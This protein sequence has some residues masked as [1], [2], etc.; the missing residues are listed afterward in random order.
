MNK[1]IK[2]GKCIWCG[3]SEPQAT[4]TTK[5][6]VV[7]RSLGADEIGFDICD[8]CNHYFGTPIN[9]TPS[10]DLAFKE[11]FNAYRVFSNNLSNETWKT[12]KSAFFT[13][14]HSKRSIKIKPNFKV[15]A[16]TNQF[17]R[18]LFEIFL[19][20]YH[21]ETGDGNNHKFDFVR[22]FARF[23]KGELR[24]YYA[25]NKILLSPD[26]KSYLQLSM[27]SELLKDIDDYGVYHF[28]LLGH[29]FY[30]E[31]NPIIFN[32]YGDNYLKIR[33]HKDLLPVDNSCRILLLENIKDLDMFMLRFNS[34]NKK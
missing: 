22:D 30:L 11:V 9:G 1:Y 24:V 21:K 16:F 18:G 26:D 14:H 12:Y 19:Q 7:P 34:K 28:W 23:A 15:A 29:N 8:D 27:S 31:F 3:K 10:I 20:K 25:F 17:K 4:F 2:T 33:A 6:H 32:L 5:P 13:Y